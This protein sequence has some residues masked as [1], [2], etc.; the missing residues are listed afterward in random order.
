ME[1]SGTRIAVFN[2]DSDNEKAP[3]L[4]GF[5]EVNGQKVKDVALWANR[6]GNG[7][8][9]TIS[10]PY[11]KTEGGVTKVSLPKDTQAPVQAEVKSELPF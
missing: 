11:N 2:N 9:G 6:N 4:K 7:F 8:N 1:K 3:A 5:I 10:E